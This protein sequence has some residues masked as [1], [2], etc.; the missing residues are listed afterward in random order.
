MT[1]FMWKLY[2]HKLPSKPPN[3]L[4]LALKKQLTS[5]VNIFPTSS[6]HSNATGLSTFYMITF[7]KVPTL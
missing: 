1:V 6:L 5:R 4:A 3:R 2:V 7:E